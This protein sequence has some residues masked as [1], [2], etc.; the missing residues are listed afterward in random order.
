MNTEDARAEVWKQADGQPFYRAADRIE[1]HD[2]PLLQHRNGQI[3][4][5]LGD[6]VNQ[7]NEPLLGDD[8]LKNLL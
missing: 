7:Q 8:D 6:A 4:R 1:S 2:G 3:I 5:G